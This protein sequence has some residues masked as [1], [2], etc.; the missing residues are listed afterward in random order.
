MF[1]PRFLSALCAVLTLGSAP[2]PAC[3]ED[4]RYRVSTD[5]RQPLPVG[6]L[7]GGDNVGYGTGVLIGECLVLSAKHVAG[8]INDP[9]G[10]RMMFLVPIPGRQAARSP[11]TIVLAGNFDT[12]IGVTPYRSND[13]MLI[14]LDRCLGRTLGYMRLDPRPPSRHSG[15]Y[16]GSFPIESA[17]FPADRPLQD[18]ATVD[19]QCQLLQESR[20]LMFNDCRGT[21]GS[22]GGPIFV[23]RSDRDGVSLVV[24][25]IQ[26]AGADIGLAEQCQPVAKI[27]TPVAALLPAI[28]PYLRQD[29]RGVT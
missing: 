3:R 12:R 14:R 7:T 9:V 20:T 28:A 5:G 10:R 4:M 22:S 19:P 27:A 23:R 6:I 2:P 25:G 17:G 18:G 1:V 8:Q 24:L 15:V 16:H 21:Y 29:D 13:W 26:T 11:A